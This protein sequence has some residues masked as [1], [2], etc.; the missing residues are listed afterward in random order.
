[1]YIVCIF[2]CLCP[3]P[4]EEHE[5]QDLTQY[6]VTQTWAPCFSLRPITQAMKKTWSDWNKR[7]MTLRLDPVSVWPNHASRFVQINPWILDVQPGEGT[8][9]HKLWWLNKDGASA[10]SLFFLHSQAYW[11]AKPTHIEISILSTSIVIIFIIVIIDQAINVSLVSLWQAP[12]LASHDF[13]VFPPHFSFTI[14]YCIICHPL[15]CHFQCPY[16]V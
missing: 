6:I 3:R 14:W 1:M 7:T 11:Q 4:L 13:K 5:E 8:R 16:D 9:L 2:Y 15:S 10:F 12:V